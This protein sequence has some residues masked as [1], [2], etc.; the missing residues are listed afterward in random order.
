M[1]LTKKDIISGI[2]NIQRVTI[3]SLGGEIY[4]QPL[5]EAQLSDLDL[6]EA[7]AMGVYESSQKGRQDAINKGKINLAKATE[8]SAEARIAKISLSINNEKNQD[9]WT[10]EEIG[11]LPRNV[12]EELITKINEISG[13]NTTKREVENF[14]ENE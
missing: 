12:I 13:V 2:N 10:D 9:T 1:V 7:K 8:A 4:L 3:E 6:I 14:P 5:S 11:L